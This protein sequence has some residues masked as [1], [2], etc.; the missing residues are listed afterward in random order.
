MGGKAVH[1]MSFKN[2]TQHFVLQ[3]SFLMNADPWTNHEM[4]SE[5]LI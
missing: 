1:S 2:W 5:Y 4:F 3:L